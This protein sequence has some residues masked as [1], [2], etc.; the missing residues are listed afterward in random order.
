MPGFVHLH[1][2]S[3]YS[4]LDGALTIN[5]RASCSWRR[6]RPDTAAPRIVADDVSRR[7]EH[8]HVGTRF[9]QQAHETIPQ[10]ARNNSETA[11][12]VTASCIST[13]SV[14]DAR[15]RSGQPFVEHKQDR[16]RFI[17]WQPRIGCRDCPSP[18]GTLERV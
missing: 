14:I 16:A 12:A 2:H 11:Q 9:G 17:F 5:C 15:L 8:A 7:R 13:D 3:S 1:V 4:L 6:A 10:C 18:S